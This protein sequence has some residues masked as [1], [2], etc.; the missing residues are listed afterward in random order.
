V[1]VAKRAW[2]SR[3]LSRNPVNE[4]GMVQ[5]VLSY[6][7]PEHLFYAAVSSLWLDAY[8]TVNEGNA[9]STST[10]AIF[11]SASRLRWASESGL[12]ARTMIAAH[13][14]I[15]GRLADSDTLAVAHEL[16]PVLDKRA[17]LLGAA[18]AGSLHALIWLHSKHSSNCPLLPRTDTDCIFDDQLVVTAASAGHVHV[19]DFLRQHGCPLGSS[20]INAAAS[21]NEMPVL[22]W[23]HQHTSTFRMEEVCAFAAAHGSIEAMAYLLPHIE[24]NP[25]EWLFSET[26]DLKPTRAL[27]KMLSI[28]GCNDQL[29]AA[30]WLRQ[31]GAAWPE[32]LRFGMTVWSGAVLA[33]AREEGCIAPTASGLVFDM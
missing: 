31:Q 28:A 4:P 32:S 11:A 30:K 7:G 16:F 24:H 25:F 5:H 27:S 18:E 2:L 12:L 23:L 8:K 26:M 17:L 15:A 1:H 14:R 6:A 13:W 20:A 21:A 29:D 22:R 10:S 33:W 19:L 9:T 3:N